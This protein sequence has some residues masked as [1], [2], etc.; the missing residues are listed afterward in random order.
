MAPV[1]VEESICP[2]PGLRPFL[3]DDSTVFFGREE[4][5]DQL[6]QKLQDRRF[7]AV[8]GTSGCGKSSLIQAGLIAGLEAGFLGQGRISWRIASMRPGDRPMRQ[9]AEALVRDDAL[10]P[11]LPASLLLAALQRGPLGLVEILAGARHDGSPV[12]AAEENLLLAIDQFEEI[13]RFRKAA[14]PLRDR[15]GGAASER[16][17][18]A[19]AGPLRSKEV[20][21]NEAIRNE[22]DAF[23]A[24]VLE[25][26]RQAGL[27][28]GPPIYVVLT[29]RSDFIGDCALFPGL[30]EAL[31]D[32][33]F[34][35]P[36]LSREQRRASIEGPA[37]VGGGRVEPSLVTRLLNDMGAMPDQLPL[38]QHAL[39][40]LWIEAG[41]SRP[42]DTEG[43]PVGPIELKQADYEAMGGIFGALNRQAQRAFEE[44]DEPARRIAEC[45]FRL[46]AERG[47]DRRD[48]RRLARLEEVAQVAAASPEAVQAVVDRFRVPDMKILDL[49]GDVLD[50]THESVLRQWELLQRWIGE[51]AEAAETY[52]QLRVAAMRYEQDVRDKGE[53]DPLGP[54]MLATALAW[55]DGDR[56][57]P[58]AW[59]PNAPWSARYGDSDDFRR[60]EEF[61]RTSE[62]A[63]H[64][65]R[66]RENRNKRLFTMLVVT[67]CAGTVLSVFLVQLLSQ[68][69]ELLEA[70]KA[71]DRIAEKLQARERDL[72]E[73]NGRLV[74]RNLTVGAWDAFNANNPVQALL[75]AVEAA[76]H[77]QATGA[78]RSRA[79]P[80][81]VLRRVLMTV[82]GRPLIGHEGAVTAAV[83][84]PDGRWIATSSRDHTVRLWDLSALPPAA[85]ERPASPLLEGN[86]RQ[87]I[88]THDAPVTGLDL[89]PDGRW[90]ATRS[91]G[92]PIRLWDLRGGPDFDRAAPAACPLEGNDATGMFVAFS[93]GGR[94]LLTISIKSEVRLWDLKAGGPAPRSYRLPKRLVAG[95]GLSSG[96]SF[97]PDEHWL[98]LVTADYLVELWKLGDTGPVARPIPNQHPIV[99]PVGNV[100]FSIDGR[101]LAVSVLDGYVFLLDLAEERSQL[102][103]VPL[104]VEAKRNAARA[105][106]QERQPDPIIATDIHGRWIVTASPHAALDGQSASGGNAVLWDLAAKHHEPVPRMLA[107]FPGLESSEI[108]VFNERYLIVSAREGTVSVWDLGHTRPIYSPTAL[109]G[110]VGPLQAL[111]YNDDRCQLFTVCSDNMVRI[112]DLKSSNPA[113]SPIIL[114]GHDR[115][116]AALALV[117]R[118]GGRLLVTAG[119]DSSVRLWNLRAFPV[120]LSVEPLVARSYN[121]WNTVLVTPR[122][123]WLVAASEG[124]SPRL[125]D[126]RLLGDKP[127]PPR[128]LNGINGVITSFVVSPNG[129][130]LGTNVA[131]QGA[132]PVSEDEGEGKEESWLFDLDLSDPAARPVRLKGLQGSVATFRVSPDCRWLACTT[133]FDGR[134][135]SLRA[136]SYL[137][138]LASPEARPIKL[139]SASAPVMGDDGRWL[140]VAS[141][142]RGRVLDLKV[143]EPPAAPEVLLR[144]YDGVALPPLISPGG[145]W[146]A[147]AARHGGI[148]LWTLDPGRGPTTL[149]IILPGDLSLIRDYRFDPRGRRLIA[150]DFSG[151]LRVW[152]LE[153]LTRLAHQPELL[154]KAPRALAISPDGRWCAADGGGND[155]LA[156]F[157]L[158]DLSADHLPTEGVDVK[159]R[160]NDISALAFSSDGRRLVAFSGLRAATWDL[161][162]PS[163][164]PIFCG[165]HGGSLKSVDLSQDRYLAVTA[166]DNSVR[167]WDLHRSSTLT[168]PIILRHR[169]WNTVT[170]VVGPTGRLAVTVLSG[171]DN[172]ARLWSLDTEDMIAV[173]GRIVGRNLSLAEWNQNHPFG[174]KYHKTFPDL[175]MPS[176]QVLQSS[177]DGSR[178]AAPTP[179]Y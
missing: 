177:N 62:A 147:L 79:N 48:T 25:T 161:G 86:I 15:S 169:E 31:N 46:L 41:K 18:P 29:M 16:T 54:R 157:R 66:A 108:H 132:D 73:E 7:V 51:E 117:D 8:V 107:N 74:T 178:F 40:R 102:R 55:L 69:S 56:V 129:R 49:A 35:T 33:Q 122:R 4:Q 165:N 17:P 65:Q 154:L 144:D 47:P 131:A 125:W 127:P 152:R 172:I 77:G 105:A 24:L 116:V 28:G 170:T 115:P 44:M 140:V 123:D 12:L 87:L 162:D 174:A 176:D 163:Q 113:A 84:A 30:P 90:L 159:D 26:I 179:A 14:E 85:S 114:R 39:M 149:P 72:S 22:A 158:W 59:R 19:V 133:S 2:Y 94:W 150:L 10:G 61:I 93:G 67:A 130:W 92:S 110:H 70:N 23:V 95:G 146:L 167:I 139:D 5:V 171:Y 101:R 11:I 100:C 112:W 32:S 121:G 34:L 109:T 143:P 96:W 148:R 43:K 38:M 57:H 104:R 52:R 3:R 68:R 58:G 98:G 103:R 9:L 42:R 63:V 137:V 81:D 45:M 164:P 80:D 135:N 89:S 141:E 6:L 83:A 106:I 64:R 88:L 120:G 151:T 99:E 1:E 53:G 75:L 153:R 76:R 168:S 50:I 134:P 71:K 138:N 166:V 124:L 97:S 21:R 13:F 60:V 118:P 136:E 173:A 156:R 128:E 37:R 160:P 155:P 119:Q 91:E 142:A 175:P 145:R 27:P 82:G 111:A 78:P 36:R 20:N 126:L